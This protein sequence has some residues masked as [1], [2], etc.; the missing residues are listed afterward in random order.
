MISILVL[1]IVV[2]VG[3]WAVEQFPMDETIRRIVR[4][5][6]IVLVVLYLVNFLFGG[7]TLPGLRW[8]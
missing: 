1:L 3:L 8:R 7:P 5:L 2:G 4:V 6:V